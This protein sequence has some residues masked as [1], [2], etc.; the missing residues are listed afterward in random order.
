LNSAARPFAS[1]PV[2]GSASLLVQILF[3]SY[4]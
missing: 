2:I 4:E 1:E 3:N